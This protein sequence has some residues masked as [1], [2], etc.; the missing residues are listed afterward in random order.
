M[1]E[2]APPDPSSTPAEDDAIIGVVFKWSL[3]VFALIAIAAGGLWWYKNRP[4]QEEETVAA[5]FV[6]PEYQEKEESLPTVEFRR[7]NEAA[8]VLFRHVNGAIGGKYLPETMGGGCAFFDYDGDQDQDLLFVSSCTWP[9]DAAGS[10]GSKSG[11]I[12]LFQNDGSG[13]FTDVSSTAGFG[14]SFYGMGPACG[15]F[16]NDGDVDLFVAAVGENVLYENR[17]GVFVDVTAAAGVAGEASAW[18]SSPAFFDYDRDGDLDLFVCNYI[19]WSKKIDEKIN[20]QLTGV[21]RAYGPPTTFGGSQPYLYRNDGGGKF[22]EV[23]AA[24]GVHVSNRSTG[25]PV[26]KGL[27]LA[28]RDLDGDGWIDLV[29]ANDTVRNFLYRNKGDGTFEELGELSGIAYS[30]DGAATGAMGV[31]S[32]RYRNDDTLGFGIGNFANEMTSLY[33]TQGDPLQYVDES[34]TE[35]IGASS[36][37]MLTF[38]LFF[39]DY[40]LDGRLDLLQANGHLEENINV[41]QPSQHYRQA[42]QLFWNRGPDAPACF[43]PVP[44]ETVGDLAQPIVGRGAAYA[45]IDAD[46]DL[47][48][49]LTEVGGEA[50]LLRNDQAEGNRWLRVRAI[51]NGST[52]NRDAIGAR[53]KLETSNGVQTRQVMP[54]RSYLSQVELPVTFGLGASGEPRALTVVWPDGSTQKV[55]DLAANQVVVVRQP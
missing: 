39:F 1:N 22:T 55:T 4:Q 29:V 17:D 33:V 41:V 40:D 12:V 18:S 20:F 21:G 14:A 44:E 53:L 49:V 26:G 37:L 23:G 8:G 54:T 31:D 11:S 51:G 7:A 24:A 2:S 13:K 47:D 32:A 6:S 36:R 19:Q 46:G 50:L 34:I 42:A 48:V 45:D 35:G 27:A 15:D 16:D 38:G 25:V 28:P 43:A 52:S 5:P 9:W 30:G 3:V 10:G